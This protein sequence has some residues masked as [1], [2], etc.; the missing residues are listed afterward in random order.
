MRVRQWQFQI[1]RKQGSLIPGTQQKHERIIVPGGCAN[2]PVSRRM[3]HLPLVDPISCGQRSD[4]H[5]AILGLLNQITISGNHGIPA[6]PEFSHLEVAEYVG[7]SIEMV[8]V[9]VRQHHG[10]EP[11]YSAR[12]QVCAHHILAD[13]ESALVLKSKEPFL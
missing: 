8:V 2:L 10:M 11:A 12:K 6:Y 9:R 3:Q 13:R 4:R 7:K 5:A 1:A